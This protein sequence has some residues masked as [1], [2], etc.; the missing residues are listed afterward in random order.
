MIRADAHC[1][2]SGS[3]S[4]FDEIYQQA[5]TALCAFLKDFH[6]EEARL[7]R[8]WLERGYREF[9]A[10][11]SKPYLEEYLTL[12]SRNQWRGLRLLALAYLHIAYDFPRTLAGLLQEEHPFAREQY[13]RVF[14]AASPIFIELAK[15]SCVNVPVVGM[16]API[17]RIL[18]GGDSVARATG[19][20]L[21]AHRCSSWVAAGKLAESGN[22]CA[23]DEQLLDG[24]NDAARR[25]FVHHNPLIWIRT[26]PFAHELIQEPRAS[27]G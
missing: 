23:L 2:L 15:A 19:N 12:A 4:A 18:P 6:P 1:L 17:L 9:Q 7:Y 3:I 16:Y 8:L 10:W 20:W 5:I 24:I 26:L 14:L 11:Q 25:V 22:R 27:A 13:R 21:L